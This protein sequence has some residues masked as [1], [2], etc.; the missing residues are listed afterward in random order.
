MFKKMSILQITPE[1]VKTIIEL[2]EQSEVVFKEY[3]FAPPTSQEKSRM[4]F[5]PNLTDMQYVSKIGDNI[6]LTVTSQGRTISKFEVEQEMEKIKAKMIEDNPAVIFSK[7][8]LKVIKEDATISVMARAPLTEPKHSHILIRPNGIVM[9]EG[10]GAAMEATISLVRKV[11]G[12]FPAFP[13]EVNENPAY[14]LKE[15]TKYDGL[16]GDIF[17]LGSKATILSGDGIEYKTKGESLDN[18]D[19]AQRIIKDPASLVTSVEVNYDGIIDVTITEN[20]TF[21]GIK[22]DKG[23]I[24]NEEDQYSEMLKVSS[25]LIKMVDDVVGRLTKE[26]K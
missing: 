25:E 13:V 20:L 14:M 19:N 23:V 4:G 24:E 21:E 17:T 16:K 12:T 10:S 1:Q 22:I 8:T 6:L 2:L 18:D 26:E 9:V 7:N 5:S 15:W 3:R 11:L